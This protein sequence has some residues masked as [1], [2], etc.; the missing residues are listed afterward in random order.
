[1][2]QRTSINFLVALATVSGLIWLVYRPAPQR[3]LINRIPE[4]APYDTAEA[5]SYPPPFEEAWKTSNPGR[6]G[7]CHSRIF[8]EWNGSMMANSWRDPA[9]RAAFLLIARQTATDGNCDVPEPPDG[10]RRSRLNP[11]ALEGCSSR[12]DLGDSQQTFSRSGSLVDGFCSR[13][14]MPT[15]Y[16]DN[17]PLQNV[18]ID[19]RSGQEHG[20]LNAHF[21]PTSDNDTGIA[22]A[23]VDNLLRNTET[24]KRGLF[25]SVCHTMGSSRDTPFHNFPTAGQEY[26]AGDFETAAS[27]GRDLL[28]PPAGDR[29]NLG[30][31]VGAGAFRMS[32]RAIVTGDVFGPLASTE[33]SPNTYLS[34]VFD[35]DL[36]VERAEFTEHRGFRHAKFERAEMCSTCHDVTNPLTVRNEFGRWV[37]GFPIERTYTEWASS[38][39]AQRPGNTSFDPAFKRDC[40]TCHM[41]QDYGQPGTAQTLYRD[42]RPVPPA[43]GE[44]SDGSPPRE[45]YFTHHFIGG[46]AYIPAR[47]GADVD[48]DSRVSPYP[49]LSVFSFSS[50]DPESPYYNAYW[51]DVDARGEVT[52]HARLAWDRLRNVL[53]LELSGPSSVDSDSLAP[54][55]IR[56]TNSGSG[57]NFPSGFPEGRAAWLAVRAFDLD[58]GAELEIHDALWQRTSLGVGYLTDRD[59]PDPNFP[60]CDWKLPAGSPDP[61][62]FQMKAV[63]SKGD[64]CPTL[65]LIYAAP[66]NLIVDDDGLPI[67]ENGRRISRDNPGGLPQFRDLDGDGDLYD[68]SYLVDSRLRPLPHAGASVRLERYSVVVPPA[69]RGP[70]AVVAA[71]Y[72]Q[73]LEGMVA[74]KFLGNLADLDTDRVLEPCVLGGACDGRTAASEPAVVEGAPPVPMEIRTWQIEV[75]PQ[76]ATASEPPAW[77]TYPSDGA[78]DVYRDVVVKV[79][80]SKPVKGIDPAALTLFDAAGREVP[81]A[82]DQIGDGT[83][84]LFPH[85]VFLEPG[86]TYT[87]RLAG[88]VCDLSGRCATAAASW[89]FRIAGAMAE[90]RGDTSVPLG[91]G[92]PTGV[93]ASLGR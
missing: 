81:G 2:A 43:S 4:P 25:C 61:Y 55:H 37:G 93:A 9:W 57:H 40:Q 54:L 22:F 76:P 1:M 20:R 87:A 23:T 84:G 36:E 65:D 41:Q 68:D 8:E 82:I 11:F 10:S 85:Q 83:W 18:E 91:F 7:S 78:E 64:G 26:P 50:A 29:T 67:D 14:H 89:S 34:E 39:Y 47:I 74:K 73:S 32:P 13:C 48:A 53:D 59:M 45:P 35:K 3:E 58:S 77:W 46:N 17:I 56:I 44:V 62:A 33:V 42:G 30:Y 70:V 51:T 49:K 21:D 12:F 80:F 79:S 71:V 60:A 28:E 88:E 66:L 63:A 15:N 75:A 16:I 92:P 69:T 90:G 27:A 31:G 72:Y 24:G 38:R 52:Q 6:C 19:P 86:A 5:Q